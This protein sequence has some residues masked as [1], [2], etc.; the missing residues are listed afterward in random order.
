M[1]NSP[2]RRNLALPEA[3]SATRFVGCGFAPIGCWRFCRV[4]EQRLPGAG[5]RFLARL[6]AVGDYQVAARPT[7]HLEKGWFASQFAN[8]GMNDTAARKIDSPTDIAAVEPDG[9]RCQDAALDSN[10]VLQR[11]GPGHSGESLLFG[12]GVWDWHF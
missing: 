10:Q 12:L 6:Q 7:E 1:F 2:A 5:D 4:R 11:N 8:L 9:P 3:A